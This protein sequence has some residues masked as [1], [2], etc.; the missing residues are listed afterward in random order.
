MYK[1]LTLGKCK[2]GDVIKTYQTQKHGT[3]YAMLLHTPYSHEDY[4]SSWLVGIKGGKVRMYGG[5]KSATQVFTGED[6]KEYIFM[7]KVSGAWDMWAK[8]L[9]KY[10]EIELSCLGGE[11]VTQV[12]AKH[13]LRRFDSG[14]RL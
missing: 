7:A 4:G 3:H 1:R 11:V 2:Q 8:Q 12:S 6:I 9:K 5:N 10:H 13:P 14:P